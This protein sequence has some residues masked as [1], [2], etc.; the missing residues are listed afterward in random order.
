MRGSFAVVIMALVLGIACGGSPPP[1]DPGWEA[2]QRLPDIAPHWWWDPVERA[3][4]D[5]DDCGPNGECQRVRLGTC[6][7]CPPGETAHVCRGGEEPHQERVGGRERGPEGDR[8]LDP[9]EPE[10]RR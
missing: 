8:T 1:R 10:P 2:S 9:R 5:D 7:N 6:P 3:C 4:E